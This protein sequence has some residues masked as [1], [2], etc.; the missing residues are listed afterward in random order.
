MNIIPQEVTAIAE[1]LTQGNYSSYLVGGSVRDLILKRKPNDWDIATSAKPKEIQDI[2][3]DSIYENNFGTVIVKTQSSD[4]TLKTIEITTLRKEGKYSDQRHPDQIEFTDDIEEDLKRRDFTID[5]MAIN[6]GEQSSKDNWSSNII[7]PFKGGEDLKKKIIRTVNNPDQRF[8]EDALRLIKAIRLSCQLDFQIEPTTFKSI[9]QNAP[10]LKRI[11]SERIRDEFIKI[12]MTSR[13]AKGVLLLEQSH[14]LHQFIPELEKG[15]GV[16]QN[17]HHIYPVWEH[18]WRALDY[19]AKKDYSLE[20]RLASLFHDIGKPYTKQGEGVNSTF[21]NHEAKG[22]NLTKKILI[23]LHFPSRIVNKV[24]KLVRYHGFVYDLD[25]TTDAA[26]RRLIRKVGLHN[27]KEL[28]QVREAD[29]IGS[30]CPKAVPF[31]LRH[32]LYRVEKI[33]QQLKGEEPSV[34]TLTIN[35]NDII[36]ILKI[37]PGPR[38]GTLLNILLEDILDNP[39][40]NNKTYLKKRIVQLNKLSETQLKKKEKQAQEKYNNILQEVDKHLKQKYY[41]S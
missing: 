39:K 12:I 22:A 19:A 9:Q 37:A 5:A 10:S 36:K 41:V 21:Y 25:V 28:A 17:K 23:R 15:I 30:G 20:V 14:L 16:T 26:I 27:I 33:G 40:N 35:G 31:R 18:L 3:P 32:F 29:R 7:D 13:A 4:P 1:K 2:F 6:L 11:A 24:E 34:K 38:V 8:Q